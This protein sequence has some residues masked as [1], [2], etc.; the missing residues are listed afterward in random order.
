[1]ILMEKIKINYLLDVF[2]IFSFILTTATAISI[3]LF[4]PGGV[5][6]GGYQELLGIQKNVWVKIH[7]YSGLFMI[8]LSFIHVLLH[9][10]WL[11]GMTKKFF[12]NRLK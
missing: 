2:L 5:R 7:T 8:L 6:R 12:K 10:K 9:L 3:F 11:I 4:L 1:M